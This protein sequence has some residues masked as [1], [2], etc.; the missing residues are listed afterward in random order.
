MGQVK[1]RLREIFHAKAQRCEEVVQ[2][3]GLLILTTLQA[4]AD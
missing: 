3:A 4:G 2:A 1:E